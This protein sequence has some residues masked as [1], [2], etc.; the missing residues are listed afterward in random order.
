[1][2]KFPDTV[3]VSPLIN[4]RLEAEGAAEGGRFGTPAESKFWALAQLTDGSK[5]TRKNYTADGVMEIDPHPMQLT[6]AS[7][8]LSLLN[9]EVGNGGA[10]V[11]GYSHPPQNLLTTEPD[12]VWNRLFAIWLDADGD[13]QFTWDNVMDAAEQI[14]EGP[15][16]IA[17]ACQES[18]GRYLHQLRALDL[19]ESQTFHAAQGELAPTQTH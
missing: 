6:L 3:Y 18:Y 16:A 19:K 5:V 17:Q 7:Q 9:K 13:P 1:M 10:W 8:A 4:F 14:E 2:H 11:V 15:W 12:T